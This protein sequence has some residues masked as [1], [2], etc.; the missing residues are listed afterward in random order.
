MNFTSGLPLHDDERQNCLC[1]KAQIVRK[2]L[3][4]RR[5]VKSLRHYQRAPTKA[6]RLRDL[7]ILG[8]RD[9]IPTGQD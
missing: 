1:A 7:R 3:K 8:E 4:R 2:G 9:E 6:D 5:G